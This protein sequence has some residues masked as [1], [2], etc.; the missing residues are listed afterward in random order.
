MLQ[1]YFVLFRVPILFCFW[2]ELLGVR[3]IYNMMATEISKMCN[4]LFAIGFLVFWRSIL[5]NN[6]SKQLKLRPFYWN[7]T[8]VVAMSC[9]YSNVSVLQSHHHMKKAKL[10]AFSLRPPCMRM[11]IK[12]MIVKKLISH[13][14]GSSAS[15]KNA[16]KWFIPCMHRSLLIFGQSNLRII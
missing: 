6:H 16:R 15:S 2:S 14:S 7:N 8:F 11:H 10:C 3:I 9:K 4:C 5:R 13:Y 12:E 1:V